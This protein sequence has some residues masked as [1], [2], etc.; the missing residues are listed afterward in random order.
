MRKYLQRLLA[1]EMQVC[2]RTRALPE[3]R[4]C[5][6]GPRGRER[7][8]EVANNTLN[9]ELKN[10]GGSRPKEYGVEFLSQ[11]RVAGIILGCGCIWIQ[12]REMR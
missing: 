7:L 3:I 4:I 1:T 6:S 8:I 12:T 10:I 2:I 11:V 5:S 9:T